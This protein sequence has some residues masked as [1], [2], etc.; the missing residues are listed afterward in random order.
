MT[1]IIH[2][3]NLLTAL[4]LSRH[5]DNGGISKEEHLL[6]SGNLGHRHMGEH[7]AWAQDAVLLIQYRTKDHIGIDQPLHQDIGLTVLTQGDGPTG[8]LVFIVTIDVDGF[9]ESH[10]FTFLHSITGGGIIGTNYGYTFLVSP[11]LEEDNHVVQGLYRLHGLIIFWFYA[12]N[13][14]IILYLCKRK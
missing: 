2:I 12:A 1:D 8:T 3:V 4:S 6:V 13:I 5:R 9:D 11:L 14:Q 7:M 10:L